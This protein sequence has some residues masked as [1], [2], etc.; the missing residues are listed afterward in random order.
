MRLLK[1]SIAIIK[2][3]QPY[4]KWANSLPD[5]D[6]EY[7]DDVFKQGCSAVII[8]EYDNE[9]EARAYINTIWKDIFEEELHGWS[10]NKN[11]YPPNMSQKMFWQWFDV[12]F[13]S[14]LYDS[15]KKN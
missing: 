2:P 12:E 14:E 15:Y 3:K 13:H 11:W 9:K 1:H 7:T 4:I 5:K 8:P 6:R 10:T